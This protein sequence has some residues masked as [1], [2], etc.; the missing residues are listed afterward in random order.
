M[1]KII[2]FTENPLLSKPT[3][4]TQ[5]SCINTNLVGMKN[6]TEC[7]LPNVTIIEAEKESFLSKLMQKF[8]VRNKPE[9]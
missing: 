1:E 9:A 4:F 6:L 7:I 8:R 2:N 3:K 5:T